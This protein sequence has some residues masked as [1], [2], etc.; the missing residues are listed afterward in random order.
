MSAAREGL[1]ATLYLIDGTGAPPTTANTIAMLTGVELSWTQNKRRFYSLGSLVPESVLDGVVE[2][3]GGFK[4]AYFTNKYMGSL[5]AG[6]WSFIGSINPRGTSV[7]AILGTIKFTGGNLRNMA[8][9]SNE[10]VIEEESFIIY[11]LTFVG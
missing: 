3:T 1:Y 6:T 11:N 10:P 9:E 7:P 5:N 8:A 2:W 4:R